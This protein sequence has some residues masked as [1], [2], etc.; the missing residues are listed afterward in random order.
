MDEA[1]IG[2]LLA[3]L[4]AEGNL[5]TKIIDSY[6]RDGLR[7][8]AD[9]EPGTVWVQV[10]MLKN[11]QVDV[12]SQEEAN[13]TVGGYFDTIGRS[14]DS[15]LKR[16]D[17]L[18]VE[19]TPDMN[20]KLIVLKEESANELI[21]SGKAELVQRI[22]VRPLNDYEEAFNRNFVRK[23]ELAERIVLVKRETAEVS[24]A[25]ELGNE[26]I[27]LRQVE[28]QKL[29]SDLSNYQQEVQ[30]L[31]TAAAEAEQELAALKEKMGSLYREILAER[32]QMG[33]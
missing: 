2:L 6:V 22:Y 28:N 15:R 27:G 21:A 14:V 10:N 16:E 7:T 26:M 18:P 9:D 29:A 33:P 5:K 25:N 12:D 24:K 4:P 1:E 3:D 11:H 31:T 13:A 8:L 23:H 32:A 30:V 19:L 17:K 20:R